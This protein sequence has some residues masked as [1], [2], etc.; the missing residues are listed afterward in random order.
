[1]GGRGVQG[2]QECFESKF[3]VGYVAL[4]LE[5]PLTD[6]RELT[7]DLRLVM[8]SLYLLNVMPAG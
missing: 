2:I 1:L 7:T 3:V 4:P 6:L 5:I 8:K